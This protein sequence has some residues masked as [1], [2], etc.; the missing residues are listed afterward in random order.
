MALEVKEHTGTQHYVHRER[1]NAALVKTN[2]PQT[3]RG[4]MSPPVS[5]GS[6]LQG[7]QQKLGQRAALEAASLGNVR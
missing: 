4:P 1:A 2:F 6:P 7:R 5:L 3:R